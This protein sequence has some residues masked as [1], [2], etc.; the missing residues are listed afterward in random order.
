MGNHLPI[1]L[2]AQHRLERFYRKF[3]FEPAGGPYSKDNQSHIIMMLTQRCRARN[4]RQ[5]DDADKTIDRHGWC[6]RRSSL[7][8]ARSGCRL[9]RAAGDCVV[10]GCCSFGSTMGPRD[11][12]S[13]ITD[14]VSA[15]HGKSPRCAR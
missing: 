11:Q 4:R 3:G 12:R 7:P 14:L 15:S 9:D 6:R 13:G 10:P 1:E 5:L 2:E 8:H